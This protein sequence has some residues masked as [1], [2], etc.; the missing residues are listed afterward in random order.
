MDLRD[1]HCTKIREIHCILVERFNLKKELDRYACPGMTQLPGDA[2]DL[3]VPFEDVELL[4][5][6]QDTS[7]ALPVNARRALSEKLAAHEEKVRSIAVRMTRASLEMV[8]A[9]ENVR[10]DLAI[11][12][13]RAFLETE[14]GISRID[15]PTYLNFEQALGDQ[16]EFIAE[17]GISFSVIKALTKAE[18]SVRREA[19]GRVH[20]GKSIDTRDVSAL[21]RK[22]SDSRLSPDEHWDRFR[23]RELQ[24]A[25]AQK[26]LEVV[27]AFRLQVSSLVFE[28][29]N[30]WE[31][32][33]YEHDSPS[34][35]DLKAPWY[36]ERFDSLQEQG[37]RLL[38]DFKEIFGDERLIEINRWEAFEDGNPDV[39]LSMA[40]DALQRFAQG[41]F[42]HN[43]GWSHLQARHNYY[44]SEII[45]S[46]NY[47]SKENRWQ[48]GRKLP[49]AR[50]ALTA[51]T[52]LERVPAEMMSYLEICAGAGGEAIGLAAAGFHPV[53][54]Y[55]KKEIAA[56][57][58]RHNRPTWN[59]QTAD[60]TEVDFTQYRGK[61][62]LLAGGVPCQARSPGGNQKGS[63][64][65][66][67]LFWLVPTMV[68]QVQP[69]AFFFENSGGYGHMP[70]ALDRTE[71]MT[72]L[73]GIG[74]DAHLFAIKGSDFGLAQHRPRVVLVGMPTGTLHRFRMPP[75]LGNRLTVATALKDLM[76]ARGWNGL[77]SFLK[78]ADGIGPT[79][80][81]GSEA[82][83]RSGFCANITMPKWAE[84]GVDG[85][86][87]A[88][89]APASDFEGLPQLTLRMGARL[90]DF[91]DT[92]K[93][94][95]N[96]ADQRR[97]IANAFPPVMA[98]AVGLAIYAALEGVD[99]DYETILRSPLWQTASKSSINLNGG[100]RGRSAREVDDYEFA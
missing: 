21:K 92:W 17:H 47:L 63:D 39:A 5:T 66:R 61:I 12:K 85:S 3:E 52:L 37:G 7:E 91:P 58:I 32:C 26:A 34:D 65:R 73:K 31:H 90:Q 2:M 6:D 45:D 16:R 27:D 79:I 29:Y 19:L 75:I 86:G 80:V 18:E 14:C 22:L 68:K 25:A 60:I 93:F 48:S 78:D 57:T 56:A 51:P 1:S 97:Q 59:V 70:S 40:H 41:L 89:E 20:S 9:I 30:L 24:K 67:D 77:E 4:E 38:I 76:G 98:R 82:S 100:D 95:G 62:D 33:V 54:L 50:H 81:G 84:L 10:K 13:L 71:I 36:Q 11:T 96:K 94:L 55:E 46:L 72:E 88:D 69:R 74:Y 83:G 99:F 44:K 8:D 35:V 43:G 15:I 53:A 87:I 28:A 42:S 49:K 64:D 23:G